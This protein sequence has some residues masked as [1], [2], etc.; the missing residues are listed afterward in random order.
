ME[1]QCNK[2]PC[3]ETTKKYSAFMASTWVTLPTIHKGLLKNSIS[4]ITVI[5]KRQNNLAN[6]CNHLEG[7]ITTK[8][9]KNNGYNHQLACTQLSRFF[10][11]QVVD[12]DVRYIKRLMEETRY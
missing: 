9:C 6:N 4:F 11:H 2:V 7:G 5:K 1:Y 8:T 12:W 3:K 10:M